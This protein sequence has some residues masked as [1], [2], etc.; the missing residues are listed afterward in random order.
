MRDTADCTGSFRTIKTA[1]KCIRAWTC[2]AQ[3][4]FTN[5]AENPTIFKNVRNANVTQYGPVYGAT[6]T[7]RIISIPA[8]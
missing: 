5:H 8:A 4:A 1:C 3:I 7:G 6:S 2:P